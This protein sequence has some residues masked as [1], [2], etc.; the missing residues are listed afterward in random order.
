MFSKV[1]PIFLRNTIEAF[2]DRML[3]SRS[4]LGIDGYYIIKKTNYLKQ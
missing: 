2:M 1:R 4:R 3:I